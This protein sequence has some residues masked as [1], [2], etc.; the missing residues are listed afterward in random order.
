MLFIVS[1]KILNYKKSKMSK[2]KW[3]TVLYC[4]ALYITKNALSFVV[5]AIS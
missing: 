4:F 2:A 5:T 3:S 1:L